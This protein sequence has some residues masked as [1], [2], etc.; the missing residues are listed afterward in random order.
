MTT[1]NSGPMSLPF[2]YPGGENTSFS[3]V[4]EKVPGSTLIEPTGVKNPFLTQLLWQSEQST[5][6]SLA[7]SL[8]MRPFLG[9]EGSDSQNHLA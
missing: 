4:P 5:E 3:I 7:R 2:N 6:H 9:L 8:V 1:G